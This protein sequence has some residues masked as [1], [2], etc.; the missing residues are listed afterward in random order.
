MI[1]VHNDS[2]SPGSLLVDGIEPHKIRHH[3]GHKS[4]SKNST[5]INADTCYCNPFK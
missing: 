1:P 3:H 2:M 4:H 5:I